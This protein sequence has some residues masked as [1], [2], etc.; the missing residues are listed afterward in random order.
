MI[1]LLRSQ[2]Q[3]PETMSYITKA[4]CSFIGIIPVICCPQKKSADLNENSRSNTNA[5]ENKQVST[6]TNPEDSRK[7]EASDDD[8]LPQLLSKPHC[9]LSNVKNGR[10][11]GGM[12]AVLDQFPFI[13]TLGYRNRW[14]PNVPKWLCG[15]SLISDRHI[16]T[17]AHCVHNRTDLYLVRLGELDLYSNSEGAE[18]EDIKVIGFKIH[19]NFSPLQRTNDIAIL[20]L[21]R[22]YTSS[23]VWPICLP[24]EEPLKSN[25]FIGTFPIVAGWG[26]LY[27]D[28]PRSSILQFIEVPVVNRNHCV[29]SFGTIGV[30]DDKIICAGYVDNTTKDT[31]QGDSGGPLM[32]AVSEG[33]SLRY[34][35]IGVVSYGFRCAESGY[36]GV[37]TRVTSFIDWIRKNIK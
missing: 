34:Y 17:A 22:K 5:I 36:P 18:P 12:P 11:V 16:L 3:N 19:E 20:T 13:V 1:N 37:Y 7:S 35:Q 25:S 15:G 24:H 14:N 4:T 6:E 10:I 26:A 31:C 27:F 9:G 28:G 30:I 29:R 2:S 32:Y 23:R 21:E 33:N 8:I